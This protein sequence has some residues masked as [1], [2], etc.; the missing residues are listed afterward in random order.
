M[1]R[2]LDFGFSK[3]HILYGIKKFLNGGSPA[4]VLDE[5]VKFTDGYTLDPSKIVV[6]FL[7]VGRGHSLFVCSSSNG[8]GK[9]TVL[10]ILAKYFYDNRRKLNNPTFLFDQVSAFFKRAKTNMFEG[11]EDVLQAMCDVDL[12][13][14]DDLDKAGA[15]TEFEMENFRLVVDTRYREMKPIFIT[16]NKNF[17]ELLNGK[18]IDSAMYS[19]LKEMC[20]V[21]NLDGIDHR[22]KS[23]KFKLKPDA[24]PTVKLP[25]K[26]SK[27]KKYSK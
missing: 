2:L 7:E 5:L 15:L 26:L 21:I 16:S 14:V 8:T 1:H 10:H 11:G 6:N 27:A 9:T 4:K 24:V 19:R 12:L 17:A 18:I 13:F 22:V 25:K 20:S 23:E 3:Y